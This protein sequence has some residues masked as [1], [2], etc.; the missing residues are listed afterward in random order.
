MRVRRSLPILVALG[1]ALTVAA[2]GDDDDD[3]GAATATTT[4]TAATT[5]AP[6]TQAPPATE[7]APAT[8]AV[9]TGAPGTVNTAP[10]TTTSDFDAQWE[11]LIAA[12]QAEGEISFVSGPGVDE[13]Q[14]FFDAFGERFGLTV[15][16]F[17]GATDEVTARV[18]AERDQGIFSY[19]IGNLGGSGTENFLEAGFFTELEPLMV[20]PDLINH[21]N[22]ATDYIPWVD[23]T[24]QYCIYYA[25]EAEGNIMAFYY[26]TETVSQEDYDSINSWFDLL[27]PRWKGR[28]V[29]GDIASGEASQDRNLAWVMLG[30]EWYDGLFANEPTVMPYGSAR[31]HADYLIRGDADLGLF[32]PGDQ[33]LQE[34]ID[35]GL[36]VAQMDKTMSE[37]SPRGVIQR[38]CVMK[39]APH[40]AA[41]QLFLNWVF[42]E[43]GGT[44]YNETTGRSGRT[45]IRLD[46]PQ[47]N[48]DDAVYQAA[49]DL[50]VP[51]LDE[52]N[53]SLLAA[54]AEADAYLAQKYEELGIVPGG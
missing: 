10:A 40:A 39:D 48:I 46:V 34:A 32:P 12:A 16:N 26:N 2:C 47:G 17:G 15:N 3:A 8:V 21:T 50:N 51:I 25:V 38:V 49:H 30:Q 44:V 1:L 14:P 18:S 31:E 36:P 42:T 5:A 28:I 7:A 45:H 29:M 20:H 35:Q 9:A 43:E 11:D 41:A 33:S 37:G 6:A 27:G 19:D 53:D 23:E 13:D 54:D 22:F 52:L 24:R 4:A